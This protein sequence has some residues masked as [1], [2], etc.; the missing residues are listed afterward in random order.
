MRKVLLSCL[1]LSLLLI[2][3]IPPSIAAGT[4]PKIEINCGNLL[5][6]QDDKGLFLYFNPYVKITF[7]GAPL[8][9]NAYYS[10]KRGD[11]RSEQGKVL[12][13][14]TGKAPSTKKYSQT[15]DL[16]YE[17]LRY[18]Q[19]SNGY[20]HM[21]LEVIDTLKRKASF[22]CI[23]EGDY[24]FPRAIPTFSSTPTPSPSPK[25]TPTVSA[26]PTPTFSP[27]PTP[28]PTPKPTPTVSATPTPTPSPTPTPTSSP[29]VKPTPTPSPT[30]TPTPNDLISLIPYQESDGSIDI[31]IV[32]RNKASNKVY[33]TT[34]G[35]AKK[36]AIKR[37]FTVQDFWQDKILGCATY[38]ECIE[39]SYILDWGGEGAVPINFDN[40]RHPDGYLSRP[41]LYEMEFGKTS[42]EAYALTNYVSPID[43][44]KS[45]IYKINLDTLV[46]TPVF[47]TYCQV[48]NYKICT[49]GAVVRDLK[50]DHAS[51]K[52]FIV[53]EYGSD[54]Y[55]SRNNFLVAYLNNDAPP[56]TLKQAKDVLGKSIWEGSV[57]NI[58]SDSDTNKSLQQVFPTSGGE[59]IFFKK[60]KATD[61][62]RENEICRSY[63]GSVACKS[64]APFSGVSI[65]QVIDR[66][67]VLIYKSD[68]GL[69][70]YNF[71]NNSQEEVLNYPRV[72]EILNFGS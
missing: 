53:I 69:Q 3:A 64:V 49:T 24:G 15:F 21:E 18:G 16:S 20:F 58:Y 42:K 9:F 72:G 59:A 33:F 7:Y 63:Q 32:L 43:G 60:G 61:S 36:T 22:T 46:K 23:F 14:V 67:Q 57:T 52:V 29:T 45:V 35:V 34:S 2:F 62:N 19:K 54:L 55:G 40:L 37:Q 39:G 65:I 68:T 51:G 41:A 25:P 70:L 11:P 47:A 6:L 12:G 4:K 1:T 17:F 44:V 38:S 48:A 50:V 26:T 28:T 30:P 71:E 27:T 10:T 13:K 31:S 56:I 8:T 5:K 66:A